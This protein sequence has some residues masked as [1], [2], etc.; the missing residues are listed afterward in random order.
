[1]ACRISVQFLQ[2]RPYSV[3]YVVL[4]V[5]LSYIFFLVFSMRE[6][7]IGIFLRSASQSLVLRMR[8]IRVQY[9]TPMPLHFT[10]KH[11]DITS[12]HIHFYML[13]CVCY[14]F[15]YYYLY[16]FFL[17]FIR[18][19]FAFR[20]TESVCVSFLHSTVPLCPFTLR[21]NIYI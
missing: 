12:D 18:Y 6:K 9:N 20:I 19:F 10:F 14:F 11:L 15:F 5:C 13:L 1:M 7:K 17:V 3:L 2:C 8:F 4:C 21:L 16:I